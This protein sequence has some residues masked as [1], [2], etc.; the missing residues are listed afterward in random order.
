M[1][2]TKEEFLKL[3]LHWYEHLAQLGF[4]DEEVLKDGKLV[5]RP[6]RAINPYRNVRSEIDKFTKEQYFRLM[7]HKLHDEAT[8]FRNEVD[9]Q[10][11]TMHIEGLKKNAIVLH[12]ASLGVFR[13]RH[14]IRHII[15]RYEIAWGIVRI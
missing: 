11:L 12:L 1:K 6:L 8:V 15:R 7:C 10:I 13:H 9:R 5:L 3:Q 4:K 2:L 14:S